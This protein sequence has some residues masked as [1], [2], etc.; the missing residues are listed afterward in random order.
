MSSVLA[1]QGS[2]SIRTIQKFEYL[3]VVWGS[4][5]MIWTGFFMWQV[6]LAM[7]LFPEYVF[8]VFVA[9]HGYEAILAFLAII[10]WHMYNVHL[11]PPVFPMSRVWLTV[12]STARNLMEKHSLEYEELR[13]KLCDG[14]PR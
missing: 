14:E 4:V 9:I 2:S 7:Q 1:L 12:R 3:A 10:I 11:S 13:R 8:D 6:E 5:V